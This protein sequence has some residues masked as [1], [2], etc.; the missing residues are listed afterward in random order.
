M[1][2]RRTGRRA[3]SLLVEAEG[4]TGAYCAQ[5]RC[6][7]ICSYPPLVLRAWGEEKGR[8]I[9]KEKRTNT[10]RKEGNRKGESESAR[11]DFYSCCP[12][13]ASSFTRVVDA[14]GIP[15]EGAPSP[16]VAPNPSRGAASPVLILLTVCWAR[17]VRSWN[18]AST[19]NITNSS[20]ASP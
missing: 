9:R 10:G 13:A 11:A 18:G 20:R 16:W 5:T 8:S 6:L 3:L 12:A 15:R 19:M 17:V 4:M 14:S 1:S 7:L 2:A